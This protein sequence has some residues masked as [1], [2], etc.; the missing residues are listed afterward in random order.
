MSFINYTFSDRQVAN[1][2]GYLPTT[3]PADITVGTGPGAFQGQNLPKA[4]RLGA[5]PIQINIS[6]VEII[7]ES[8]FIVSVVFQ[9]DAGFSGRQTL[10]ESERLPFTLELNGTGSTVK[11]FASVRVMGSPLWRGTDYFSSPVIGAGW[12]LAQLVYDMDTLFVFLDGNPMGCHGFGTTGNIAISDTIKTVIAGGKDANTRFKG[13]LASLQVG[14]GIPIELEPL[15]D[16]QRFSPQ[17]FISTKLEMSRPLVDMGVS[18][19]EAEYSTATMTWTQEY[20][21]GAI[22]YHSAANSAFIMYGFIYQRYKQLSDIVKSALGY[23]VSDE[24]SAYAQGS[25]KSLFQGGGILRRQVLSNPLAKFTSS[26][27]LLESLKIGVCLPRDHKPSQEEPHNA[28]KTQRSTTA[29]VRPA[30]ILSLA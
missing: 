11:L 24:M 4:I 28:R 20:S 10:V 9:T 12:H 30:H 21:Q 7:N 8:R 1:P 3:L 6:N 14:F 13:L 26:T 15:M 23:L 16:S 29:T 2:D 22:S 17:W 18:R 25:R 19:S 5:S 27:R